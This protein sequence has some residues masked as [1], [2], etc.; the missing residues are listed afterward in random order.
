MRCIRRRW[1]A[2][3]YNIS[4]L[5][6]LNE[7]INKLSTKDIKLQP[8]VLLKTPERVTEIPIADL[9][10]LATDTVEDITHIG[11]VLVNDLP[12]ERRGLVKIEIDVSNGKVGFDLYTSGVA[13]DVSASVI[14]LNDIAYYALKLL[15]AV[16]AE[17][18]SFYDMFGDLHD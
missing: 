6:E 12:H 13:K 10:L 3:T 7:R 16:N 8:T 9:E 1:H 17:L 4:D 18:C 15:P 11:V 14:H 5:V 2:V